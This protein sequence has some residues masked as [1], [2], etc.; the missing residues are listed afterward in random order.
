M[1]AEVLFLLLFNLNY[2]MQRIEIIMGTN[3]LIVQ[4]FSSRY[5]IT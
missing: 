3:M 1:D 4:S 2:V 5:L